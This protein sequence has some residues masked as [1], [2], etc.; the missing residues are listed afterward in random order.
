[1]YLRSMWC[2]KRN[3][4]FMRKV[5]AIRITSTIL[6]LKSQQGASLVRQVQNAVEVHR[7]ITG[8]AMLLILMLVSLFILKKSLKG[9]N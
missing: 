1:M 9:I 4:R 6:N 7:D 2:S 5:L 3:M 8:A